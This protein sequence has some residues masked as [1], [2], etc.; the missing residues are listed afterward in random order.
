MTLAR[1]S[2]HLL[3][4]VFVWMLAPS[5]ADA[6]GPAGA[7]GNVRV[8]TQ[9]ASSRGSGSG[10]DWPELVV[11]GNAISFQA[12][13]QVG[14]G[15]NANNFASYL[16]RARFAFQ[17][18]YQ[19]RRAHWI[20]VGV[21]ALFDRASWRNFRLD[22]CG[23]DEFSGG[24]VCESG[25]VAG[26]DIYAGY[27]H[28]WFIRKYPFIVPIARGSVGFSYWGLPE[29]GGGISNRLQE[30]VRTWALTLRAGG[31]ARFFVL[32]QLG[33][34]GDL[35][36]PIGFAINT[37]VDATGESDRTAKFVLG[38]EILPIVVEYRF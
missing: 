12:P 9:G 21:A 6:A 16:P 32:E 25:S 8:G 28:K 4:L 31:G 19:L 23:L 13:L 35:N 11:G 36:L 5:A 34:G 38:L 33:I 1:S 27:S 30:R 24:N 29:L 18:D 17:Y 14:F 7:S 15:R 37:D 2:L 10:Y 26:F 20:H 3:V 22:D